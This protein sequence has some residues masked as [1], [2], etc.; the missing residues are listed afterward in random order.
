[1]N[2]CFSLV[3]LLLFEKRSNVLHGF[4]GRAGISQNALDRRIHLH[5][6]GRGRSQPPLRR[7]RVGND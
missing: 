3:E 6:I 2:L 4:V 5:N 1:M 7:L